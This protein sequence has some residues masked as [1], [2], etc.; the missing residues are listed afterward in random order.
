MA[1]YSSMDLGITDTQAAIR[2]YSNYSAAWCVRKQDDDFSIRDAQCRLPGFSRLKPSSHLNLTFVKQNLLRGNLTLKLIKD[3]P[4]DDSPDFAMTSA[5]WLPVQA[6]YAIHGFGIACLAAKDGPNNLP[7][8]HGGFIRKAESSLV[9]HLLPPP[10]GPELRNGYKGFKYLEPELINLP[11]D[12]RFIGSG[13]NLERPNTETRGAH[14]A[15]CLDTTRRRLIDE[16]LDKERKRARKP[17]KR[18]GVLKKPTQIEIARN[19]SPT[20]VLDYLYRVRVKSNYE[21]PTMYHD[22][23]DDAET[24]IELVRNTQTLAT[25]LCALCAAILWQTI[26]KSTRDEL[27]NNYWIDDLIHVLDSQRN[28][29]G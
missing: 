2:T 11:D 6:Y 18:N 28:V 15:Q 21:D 27:G 20:T 13:L 7:Q 23:S 19:V 22:G 26:D 5:L 8:T 16:K 12:R 24:V 29:A 25:T 9:R 14:I 1:P 17:G 3:I 10:F 4:V